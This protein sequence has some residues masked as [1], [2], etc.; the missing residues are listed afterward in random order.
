MVLGGRRT[1]RAIDLH[2]KA[3]VPNKKPIADHL[4]EISLKVL[5]SGHSSASQFLANSPEY[6]GA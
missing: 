5:G 4:I 2:P 1:I 6:C 3:V